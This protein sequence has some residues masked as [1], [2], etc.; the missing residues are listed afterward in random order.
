MPLYRIIAKRGFN[1]NAF[2]DQVAAI[3]VSTLEKA[4][5]AG[6]SVTPETLLEKGLTRRKDEVV[7]ILGDGDL[8]IKLEVK[9]HRV[10]KSAEEKIKA[11]G[12]SV[13]KLL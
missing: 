10:S 1:N 9:V 3:N 4:F 11:A 2:A 7:K 8:T 5:A 6:D 13:E 12:G